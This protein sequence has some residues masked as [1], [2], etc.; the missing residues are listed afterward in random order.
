M[1]ET[2]APS[3][4]TRRR[5]LVLAVGLLSL[6]AYANSI[7]A[8]FVW[9][10]RMLVLQDPVV[11]S[12]HNLGEVF[13]QDFFART[14]SPL[15][16]GYYRP[17][18]TLSYVLDY[19]LSGKDPLVYH[20]TNVLLHGLSS[21]LAL[22]LLWRLGLSEGAGFTA[23]ALFAVHPI[24]TESVAWIAGRTDLLA[25]VLMI[26]ALLIHLAAQPQP[27]PQM[28]NPTGRKH[29]K[30]R[31]PR[32]NGT[33]AGRHPVALTGLALVLFAAALL[34]KEMAAVL[35]LWVALIHR[36]RLGQSWKRSARAAVPYFVVMLGYAVLRFALAAVA[37][38]TTP[39]QHHLLYAVLTA[40]VTVL[41][42][43][44]WMVVP[45]G[46]SAYV[47]NPYVTSP[48][49]PRFFVALAALALLVLLL[50]RYG[51]RHR[52]AATLAAMLAVSFLPILN[53]VRVASPPDMGN[54]M[55]ERF[56]YLPSLPFIALA[57][58]LLS[59]W[60]L[61][62]VRRARSIVAVAT[63]G[64]V[65][66]GLGLTWQRNRDWH[67]EK[68]L[69]EKT[70]R[71]VPDAPL[72]WTRLALAELRSGDLP[73]AQRSSNRASELAPN[74]SS[75]LALRTTMLVNTGHADEA[76]PIQER[77]V[78]AN[79]KGRAIALNNLA[80]LYRATGRFQEAHD[81]LQ[82]LVATGKASADA[83]FN[84]AEVLRAEGDRDGAL[85]E[86][87]V[88]VARRPEDARMI[89]R[90]A[91]LEAEMGHAAASIGHY[92]DAITLQPS[93]ARLHDELG[94][95]L[96]DSGRLA[97]AER[98]F[99]SAEKLG[100][101]VARL[102]LAQLMARQGRRE[103]ARSLLRE[104][105]TATSDPRLR[106]AAEAMIRGLGAQTP[107]TGT[108]GSPSVNRAVTPTVVQ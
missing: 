96:A 56:C 63:T 49:D 90:L 57:V 107:E 68:T 78:S 91:S 50:L 3:A 25:F 40:P 27:P 35:P 88:A 18:T 11:H 6:A 7:R 105:L 102:E 74:M 51:R 39:G 81:I 36:L 79:Q 70:V 55:A 60:Q 108:S 97:E 94:R 32:E 30:K 99:S 42:Y 43:L 72:P 103:E 19:A 100:S 17:V 22:L 80:Y 23:A 75:V 65:A 83:H 8:G 10:D 106:E 69:F 77:L 62:R 54:T 16:Y 89:A 20:L 34:S 104:L 21:A 73:A 92:R 26:S 15:P 24:H 64:L 28:E 52:T 9:D 71:Q 93:S 12:F 41:R 48:A 84:L 2:G 14:E 61:F 98:A 44:G 95:A 86:Y 31:K 101:S 4:R 87:R 47:Q 38:P 67:D 1:P 82:R 5:L 46:L 33:K 29:K 59:R 66:A 37:M 13:S 85:S 58:L 76:V 53:F 45:T